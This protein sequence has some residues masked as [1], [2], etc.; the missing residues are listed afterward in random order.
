LPPRLLR[1][2]ALTTFSRALDASFDAA[3]F[4]LRAAPARARAA[5]LRAFFA[6]ATEVEA[7][8]FTRTVEAL[9]VARFTLSAKC[10][11]S[12]PISSSAAA[13]PTRG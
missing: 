11:L 2:A 12:S 10:A 8:F 5:P 13:H 9:G 3:P 7:P 4:T 1:R 6:A